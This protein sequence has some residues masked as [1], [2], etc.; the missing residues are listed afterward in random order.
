MGISTINAMDEVSGLSTPA[1]RIRSPT[2][3][4]HWSMPNNITGETTAVGVSEEK[5]DCDCN[6]KTEF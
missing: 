5:S 6:Y 1:T 4:A 2:D 3:G